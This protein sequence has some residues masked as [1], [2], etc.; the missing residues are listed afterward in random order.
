MVVTPRALHRQAQN[1]APDGRDH[2][3]QIIEPVLRIVLLAEPDFCV[4]PQK[5]RRDQAFVADLLELVTRNLLFQKQVIRLVLVE[6]ADYI[7]AVAPGVGP[8]EIVLKS[9]GIGVASYVQPVASPALAIM[10]RRQQAVD[11]TL[12]AI[13]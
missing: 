2:V 12:P 11:Q 13:G 6:G 8:V 5:A 4:A 9:V 3:V 1:A 7:V 10:R